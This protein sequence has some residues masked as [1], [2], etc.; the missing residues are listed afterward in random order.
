MAIRA[1]LL[2]LAKALSAL[3]LLSSAQQALE[4]FDEDAVLLFHLAE[5]E[6]PAGAAGGFELVEDVVVR[7]KRFG[8]VADVEA[9]WG[10]LGGD[11]AGVIVGDQLGLGLGLGL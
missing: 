5:F 3:A 2:H 10:G 4:L 9:Q 8:L 1:V 11:G 6:L 7:G